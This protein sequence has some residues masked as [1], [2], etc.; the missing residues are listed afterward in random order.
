MNNTETAAGL[1]KRGYSPGQADLAMN[2]A[3]QD[4]EYA[5]GRH[6]VS[7][8]HDGGQGGFRITPL[9][10]T[11]DSADGLKA[12]A[13][14]RFTSLDGIL[15]VI[16]LVDA[17]LDSAVAETYRSQPLAQ[18]WARTAKV[19]EEAGE[20]ISELI[21]ITGQN[22]RKGVHSTQTALL[23]ELGDVVCTGLFAIQHFTKD[24]DATWAVITEALAK[25]MSRVPGESPF[26]PE[27]G[28][29]EQAGPFMDGLTSDENGRRLP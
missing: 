28:M 23:K 10:W 9:P 11:G 26:P 29:T 27:P 3:V 14:S 13:S 4:G 2:R 12:P 19:T 1:R 18:D 22:P 24:A 17:H 7:Y 16:E 21:A 20:A 6:R 8:S 5:L 15:H 25:A